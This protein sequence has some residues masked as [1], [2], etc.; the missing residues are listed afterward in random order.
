MNRIVQVLESMDSRL[1]TIEKTLL[2]FTDQAEEIARALSSPDGFVTFG[3]RTNL[4]VAEVR[5]AFEQSATAELE[6]ITVDFRFTQAVYM[7]T[8]PEKNKEL[9]DMMSEGAMRQMKNIL[10]DAKSLSNIV[11]KA[12]VA[13]EKATARASNAIDLSTV[14]I[15][16]MAKK[17]V[18]KE[19]REVRLAQVSV[20]SREHKVDR[21]LA[22]VELAIKK[23]EELTAKAGNLIA[24]GS[25]PDQSNNFI[26]RRKA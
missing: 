3:G 24:S 19:M 9:V 23:A 4:P 10:T 8:R 7:G 11:K 1:S 5:K 2:P 15:Q 12:S 16:A 17:E 14:D 22:R 26:S 13:A 25:P 21:A 6:A 18:E 20:L